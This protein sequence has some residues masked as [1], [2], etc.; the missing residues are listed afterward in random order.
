MTQT[1]RTADGTWTTKEVNRFCVRVDMF[2]R[3][4]LE[5]AAAEKLAEDCLERDRGF[6]TPTDMH[7]CIECRYFRRDGTCGMTGGWGYQKTAFHRCAGFEW[8]VPRATGD[9]E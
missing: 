4:G 1:Q 9:G 7:A 2:K 8:Q 3:R 6:I 5:A